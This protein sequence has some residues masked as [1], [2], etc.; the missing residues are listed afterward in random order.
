MSEL[1]GICRLRTLGNKK[2]DRRADVLA[3]SDFLFSV[4]PDRRIKVLSAEPQLLTESQFNEQYYVVEPPAL[5]LNQRR[6]RAYKA[7]LSHEKIVGEPVHDYKFKIKLKGRED[8]ILYKQITRT[9][10][11]KRIIREYKQHDEIYEWFMDNWLLIK[12]G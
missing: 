1:T 11:I 9:S 12:R 4:T 8:V 2:D 3:K 7:A 5:T 10:A 6:L